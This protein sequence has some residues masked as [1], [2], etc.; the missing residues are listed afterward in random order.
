MSMFGLNKIQKYR[1]YHGLV[2]LIIVNLLTFSWVFVDVEYYESLVKPFFAPPSW[3]FAPV[4]FINGV[5]V[6]VGNIWLLNIKKDL[7][8]GEGFD[9]LDKTK[10]ESLKKD[11]KS[12][13]WLQVLSWVN[14]VVFSALSFGTKIVA[15]FFLPTFSMWLL[16]VASIFFAIKIDSL[17][18]EKGFWQTV[19]EGKS[20]TFTFSTLIIWLTL[21]SLLGVFVWAWN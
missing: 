13:V 9:Y 20:I 15:M 7:E 3:L 18:S 14:Y 12:L 5:L 21:A 8:M 2:F 17:T 6:V 10:K 1:W 16:T 4:W 19:K 11:V